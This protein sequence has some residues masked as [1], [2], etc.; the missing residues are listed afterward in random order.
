MVIGSISQIA[1][2]AIRLANSTIGTSIPVLSADQIDSLI[3]SIPYL[4]A[5]ASVG[6][7]KIRNTIDNFRDRPQRPRPETTSTPKKGEKEQKQKRRLW[8]EQQKARLKNDLP[9]NIGNKKN[10]S[11]NEMDS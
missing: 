9:E 5:A 10:Q 11:E 6:A 1:S 8:G 3:V 2:T 4:I 7:N